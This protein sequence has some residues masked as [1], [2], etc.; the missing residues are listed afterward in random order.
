MIYFNLRKPGEP[1][2]AIGRCVVIAAILS[3][4]ALMGCSRGVRV[5]MHPEADLSYYTRV[6]VVPFRSL[7]GDR[8]AGEK[9]SIEFNTALLAAELFEVV[10]Y[11]V[12]ANALEKTIGSR[13]PNDG[14]TPEE[15]KKI[16]E[17]TGI[18]GIFLGTVSQYAMVPTNSGTFPVITVEARL[19]D[20]E[21]GTVVWMSTMSERGGPKTPIVG[22]GE[23]HTL[24]ALSQKMCKEMVSEF[25]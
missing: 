6:G 24:G 23:I 15:L 12:F 7:A 8:F 18:Q 16:S 25:K 17:A 21:T 3:L 4:L 20:T 19:I 9:L 14:L 5:Y 2:A 13:S 1:T 10:D 11:G 22:I